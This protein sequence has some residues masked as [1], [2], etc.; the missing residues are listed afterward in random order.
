MAGNVKEWCLNATD[1]SGQAHYLL[2]GGSGEQTYM[3]GEE[4]S[5]SPWNRSP[6]NGFR[7]VQHPQGEASLA[8][9]L[10][11]PLDL[12]P[13]R[14][15]SDLDSF[16]DEEF[17]SLKAQYQYDR[18]PLSP[19][20]EKIENSSPFWRKEKITFNAAYD[21][22]R[23][24]AYLFL[25]K[26]ANPPYQ[27]VI[28]FPGA[29][30]VWTESFNESHREL[31]EYVVTSGRALLYPIY[32]GTYERPAAHGRVWTLSSIAQ[33]PLAY[34]DW[35]IRM[36][37]DLRR[38]IDYLETR[39]DIDSG[40][41]AYYGTCLGGAFGP[42]MLAVEDRIDTGIF[43]VGHI[44]LVEL[45]RSVDVALYAER[46]DVPVLMVNGREDFIVQKTDQILYERLGTPKE[47]KEHKV[48]PGGHG[49]YALFH[50]QIQADVLAWLDRYLGQVE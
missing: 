39:H 29:D 18:T 42:I 12:Y 35:A 19:K 10:F 27:T 24:I 45:P 22:E 30:A 46:V 31:T 44:P 41:V 1:D 17:R 2:G 23:M 47:H 28:F 16:T 32:Y 36:V 50:Q 6:L 40:R 33:T 48:Y 8:P 25:P 37:K 14:D 26:T 4:D 13:M 5:L 20:V 21:N 49:I 11:R 38:C 9:A 15:L 3:F 7:C 34:R 43:L